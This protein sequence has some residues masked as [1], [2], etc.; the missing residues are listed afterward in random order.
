MEKH[1]PHCYCDECKL[2]LNQW[3]IKHCI[4]IYTP[5]GML[6]AQ[7]TRE[8]EQ[9]WLDKGYLVAYIRLSLPEPFEFEIV[10]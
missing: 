5:D 8:H 3:A 4:Y 6:I 1:L 7:S 2:T 10:S 9:E